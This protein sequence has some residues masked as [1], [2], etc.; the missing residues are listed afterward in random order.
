MDDSVSSE[1]DQ[2]VAEC[3]C[4]YD[5]VSHDDS[6]VTFQGLDPEEEYFPM[7]SRNS[8]LAFFG[9]PPQ[10]IRPTQTPHT[11]S[12]GSADSDGDSEDDSE[13]ESNDGDG[14]EPLILASNNS[15]AE[16]GNDGSESTIVSPFQF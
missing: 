7:V 8:N 1:E 16:G 12:D 3:G 6:G 13:E 10:A 4:M 14:D 5:V 9:V 11:G 15:Q 2:G